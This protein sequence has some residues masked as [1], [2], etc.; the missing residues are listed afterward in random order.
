[1]MTEDGRPVA[2]SEV[3]ICARQALIA[4][5]ILA[6]GSSLGGDVLFLLG[7]PLTLIGFVVA[8]RAA[9]NWGRPERT[10][11]LSPAASWLV[12]MAALGIVGPTTGGQLWYEV[13]KRTLSAGAIVAVGILFS[14]NK[15]RK[16]RV[17]AIAVSVGV[18]LF[19][20][21]PIGA[22]SPTIDVFTWT[23][24]SV[25]ALLHRVHP[26]TVV[27][28]DVYGGRHDP[29]Y[30]VSA[31]PY[32]PATLLVYAPWVAMLGD[33]RFA[34]A[35]AI[36]LTV[37]LIRRVSRR[38]DVSSAFASA[39]ALAIV[40]H[41][42]GP[43]MI[44]SGWTEPLLVV[45]AALFVDV[46]VRNPNGIGEAATFLLLPALKQYVVAPVILYLIRSRNVVPPRAMVA[47]LTISAATVL[48][49]LIWNWHATL[50][51]MVFQMSAPTV[52]RLE[53]TSLV[54]LIG[55]TAGVYPGRWTSA[56]VQLAVG[57]IVW[58]RLPTHGLSG[59]LLASALSLY[60]TFLVGW[61]AFVNYYYFVGALLILAAL[62]RAAPDPVAW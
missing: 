11:N 52:P 50:F 40:L 31:Y 41:P 28:P 19:A 34:L 25:R 9:S 17:A 30:T 57:A 37:G 58:R 48:P 21:G 1:M 24:T 45:T 46:A 8:C 23:Q 39:A 32:M 55:T 42:S 3:P 4:A 2:L 62:I 14:D 60:A 6:V 7:L 27:A 44:E 10:A 33:F 16:R 43:R 38:L 59:L 47:G 20:L 5:L 29:G 26:Y 53:S 35:A 56:V 51:G 15:M 18:L 22:P 49:F 36:A 54:A 61:Q 13:L 12:A